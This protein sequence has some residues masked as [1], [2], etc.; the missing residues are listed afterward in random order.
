MKDSQKIAYVI[1]F[2]GIIYVILSF[3]QKETLVDYKGE[4]VGPTE[5]KHNNSLLLAFYSLVFLSF[6]L[7]NPRLRNFV[8]LTPIIIT[9]IY[10]QIITY[11]RIGFFIYFIFLL[12]L[13]LCFSI[14]ISN[15]YRTLSILMILVLGPYF[16]SFVFK[17]KSLDY[18]IYILER[19]YSGREIINRMMVSYVFENPLHV[20]AGCGAGCIDTVG[21][22][23]V[24][25]ETVR[26]S[27]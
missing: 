18:V 9:S 22:T 6:L 8:I 19:G 4:F 25:G 7:N 10:L 5:N 15:K 20:L 23:I 1:L 12:S 16:L 2:T 13:I 3:S 24:D 14:N 27:I 21:K 11:A 17:I 26:D